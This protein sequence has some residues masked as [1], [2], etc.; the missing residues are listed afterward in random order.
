[1]CSGFDVTADKALKLGAVRFVA[2]PVEAAALRQIVE[3]TLRGRPVADS[4][5]ANER[6]FVRAARARSAAAAVRLFTT[7]RAQA[8]GFEHM[9]SVFAENVSSYFGFA[10]AGVLF[11]ESD[12]GIRVG[13]ASRASWVPVGARFPGNLLFSTGVLAGGSSLVFTDMGALYDSVLESVAGTDDSVRSLAL[14]LKF[15]VAVPLHYDDLPIGALVLFDRTQHPFAAEDLLILEGIGR[16]ASLGLC[17]LPVFG[18]GVVPSHLF[19]RMLGA[20]LCLLHRQRGALELILVETEPAVGPDQAQEVLRRG[21][22][23]LVVCQRDAGTL[24]IYKRDANAA[25]AASTISASLATLLATGTVRATG[26][27][28]IVDDGSPPVSPD[29]ALQLAGFALDESR[30]TPERCAERF[31]LG[32]GPTSIATTA[33]SHRA[34][35]GY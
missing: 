6:A 16:L 34:G 5:L 17:R 27:V 7:L 31:V 35:A 29:V 23:R 14:S 18:T 19:D 15:L 33:A 20:E 8:S 12:G 4:D 32:G 26:W 22:P 13:G 28:S 11:V 9:V 21:S 10:P 25:A 1:V 2:K 24:A 30:S 3:Q